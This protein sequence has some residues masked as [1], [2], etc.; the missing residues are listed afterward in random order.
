MK[1]LP[2]TL[3]SF[4]WS[5]IKPQFW[6]FLILMLTMF[7]WSIQE[8]VYP[9]F[10][11]LIVDK[12]SQNATHKTAIFTILAPTLAAFVALWMTIEVGYRIYDFLSVKVFPRFRADVRES[13]FQY[14]AKHSYQYYSDNFV[15]SI[16]S[17][18]SRLPEALERVISMIFTLIVPIIAAFIINITLL[19]HAKPVFA[20]V[21]GGWFTLHCAIT[22]FFTRK[23]AVYSAD[24]SASVTLLNGKIV[25]ILTNIVNVRLFANQR[26]EKRYLGAFQ[27]IE[28]QKSR[29]LMQYNAWMKLFLGIA[30]QTFAFSM[31]GGGVYAWQ[32]GWISL[33]ELTLV[34]SSLNLIG[35]A[36]FMG[37]HL[38]EVYENIGTCQE[39]LSIAQKT[40]EIV[41]INDA[42]PIEIH[43][44]EIRF[45]EVNF[46]YSQERK[47]F[48]NKNIIIHAGEKVGLV[49]FSGSGKTTFVNLILRY[50][51]VESGRILID[52]QDIKQVTQDS[53]RAQIALI[54]QDTSLFHRSLLENIRYGRLEASDEEVIVASKRAHCHEFIEHLDKQYETLVGERGIKLS[55]GQR[56]RI[57]IARAMLKNAPILILDEATSALDS[58]TEKYIQESLRELMRDRTTIVIAHRLSTLADM[59]RI[60]VFN[61]GSIVEDGTHEELL[62]NEGHYAHLWKMQT[63]GFLPE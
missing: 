41:D 40:I 6:R 32:Q 37:M 52:N 16:A 28:V 11:K 54:P 1:T 13:L 43:Q 56:Q 21:M 12:V 44:G 27:E 10:I 22:Y 48:Q 57:A 46:H 3:P 20:Y 39:A 62:K 55:G 36:W 17:K 14:A 58:V 38:I 59:S 50:F 9:Y 18:I 15:G 34:L 31:I 61:N 19:Y 25:D 47:L 33:G 26:F 2:K 23:C 42:K 8:A 24:H 53:L 4:V 35:L 7:G 30:S 5:F 45:E 29:R 63:S 60:L 49:G 51:E